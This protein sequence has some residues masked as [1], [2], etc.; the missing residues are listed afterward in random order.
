MIC[1]TVTQQSRRLALASMLNAARMSADLV[2]VRLDA[3]DQQPDLTEFLAARRTPILMSCRRQRDGG[4]WKG[5]EEARLALLRQAVLAG[6]DY[7]A[8]E[9]DVADQI[10]PYGSTKRVICY[11]NIDET[12]SHVGAICHSCREHNPDIIQFACRASTPEEAWPLLQLL[13]HPPVPISVVGLGSEC[14]MP[15]LLGRKYG[16]AWV[17][18]AAERG[19][20]AY[21]GQ[22]TVRDLIDIYRYA[23]IDRDTRWVGVTGGDQW[24]LLTIALLNAAFAAQGS[25][26]RCL[27]VTLGDIRLFQR[28]AE[29][30]KLKS[31]VI[32]PRDQER[33]RS[34][35]TELDDNI[36][37][38][39]WASDGEQVEAAVDVLVAN[40]ANCWRGAS[41]FPSAALA[42]LQ[43]TLARQDKSLDGRVV[44][45]VGLTAQSIGL[46]RKVKKS[47][48]VLIFA[49][50]DQKLAQQF[51]RWFGGRHIRPEA[52]FTTLHDVLILGAE[53][54]AASE[55]GHHR[56]V[57]HPGF[58]KPGMTMMDLSARPRPTALLTEAVCRGCAV[59]EPLELLFEQVRRLG[60]RIR[61]E[62][63]SRPALEQA[64]Q[65][66]LADMLVADS[67]IHLDS[68]DRPE[69]TER[70]STATT[71]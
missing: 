7:V 69:C 49:D 21:P 68:I 43:K 26:K 61:G 59:V 18:A 1:V 22:P 51:S 4:E 53:P 70:I 36:R 8:I 71:T 48:G 16:A 28:F 40:E 41:V 15:A 62:E 46:V 52:V 23:E 58:L 3:F 25:S 6:V 47:G 66:L 39:S 9:H 29:R 37:F 35:A 44:V 34:L 10:Q 32:G 19:T 45:F 12:P 63:A 60:Y 31:I 64:M 50:R 67:D 38:A 65:S 30:L 24:A 5:S 14:L 27:P 2:E 20:E 13:N 17:S 54:E 33:L 57:S 11:T 56:Q 55:D 42:V